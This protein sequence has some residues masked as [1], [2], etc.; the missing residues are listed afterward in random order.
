MPLRRASLLNRCAISAALALGSAIAQT[1]DQAA[2]QLSASVS[3]NPP[4]LTFSWV[5]DPTATSYAVARRLFGSSTWGT[6]T[7]I[8]GGAAA[9]TWT[10]SR[11]WVCTAH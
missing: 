2:I 8:P 4:A 6:T 11:H 9:T 5:P 1:A 10:D 3:T 7:T